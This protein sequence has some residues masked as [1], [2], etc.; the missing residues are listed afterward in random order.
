MFYDRMEIID[1][2]VEENYAK[3]VREAEWLSRF[4]QVQ[5]RKPSQMNCN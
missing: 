2:R 4:E 3:T 1:K 5:G